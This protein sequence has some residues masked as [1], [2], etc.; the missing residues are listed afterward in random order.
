MS[1]LQDEKQLSALLDDIAQQKRPPVAQ[2]NPPLRGH[3][4]MVIQRDGSWWHKGT[5]IKKA[6]LVKLFSQILRKEGDQY[7]LVTPVE[8]QEVTVE[9]APFVVT[10][11]KSYHTNT[12]QH[13]VISF[14]TNVGDKIVL[15][16]EYPLAIRGYTPYVLVR[17]ALE[18]RLDTSIY[19]ECVALAQAEET[20]TGTQWWLY[21]GDYKA[22]LGEE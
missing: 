14:V 15:A 21:S 9:D 7:F 13:P 4:Q 8:K 20:A 18:A 17:D 5:V 2:W 10:A 16:E 3:S 19:Y 6:T 11:M 12:S 22:L 1:I